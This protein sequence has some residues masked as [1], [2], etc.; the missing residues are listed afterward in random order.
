M[1]YSEQ[2]QSRRTGSHEQ[3]QGLHNSRMYEQPTS[4]AGINVGNVAHGKSS[5]CTDDT[6]Q[7]WDVAISGVGRAVALTDSDRK[8]RTVQKHSSTEQKLRQHYLTDA[9]PVYTPCISRRLVFLV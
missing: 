2:H 1:A 9:L 6:W 8:V 7:W 5:Q 4:V 3:T